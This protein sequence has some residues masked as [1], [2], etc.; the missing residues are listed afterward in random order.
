M[1]EEVQWMM[2]QYKNGN[3]VMALDVLEYA[4]T[5]YSTRKHYSSISRADIASKCG[6][7]FIGEKI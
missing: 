2:L 7:T 1:K 6:H 3:L 5:A 4:K